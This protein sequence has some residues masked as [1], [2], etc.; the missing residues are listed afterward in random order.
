VRRQELQLLFHLL[1]TGLPQKRQLPP[2]VNDV[3]EKTLFI[4]FAQDCVRRILNSI[5]L[6]ADDAMTLSVILFGKHG[7]EREDLVKQT[8]VESI[9]RR[10]KWS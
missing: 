2:Y 10:A 3:D 8:L 1:G 9:A 4:A 6:T 5:S 7:A